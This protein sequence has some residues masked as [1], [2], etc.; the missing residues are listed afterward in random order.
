MRRWLAVGAVSMGV[1]SV[2]LMVMALP[3][4]GLV[5]FTASPSGEGQVVAV[6]ISPVAMSAYQQAALTVTGERPDCGLRWSMVAGIGKKESNHAGGRTIAGD[7][8]IEQPIIGVA[9]DGRPGLAAISDTDGGRYDGDT[10]WDRAVGP[11][12]FIPST[13]QGREADGNGDGQADPHNYYDAALSTARK[14]CADGGD[15]TNSA[16]LE[17]AVFAY[18]RST[19][20]VASVVTFIAEYDA[21]GTSGGDL[22]AGDSA[23]VALAEAQSQ[24]GKP[25][26]WAAEGPHSFDCS[27]LTLWSYAKAG[28]SI[29]R[30]AADQF[31]VGGRVE[32]DQLAPGDLVFFGPDKSDPR[33]ISH[34][35]LYMGDG[36]MLSAPRTG[37]LVRVEPIW[38]STYVGAVRLAQ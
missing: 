33:S 12:Q 22:V 15:L 25:Y 35:G 16:N 34:V 38:W 28:I 24:I 4:L 1:A 19:E 2:P 27:G 21:L 17:R 23:L 29:P 3:V 13:W 9:L 11:M 7:G 18:N 26:E 8:S 37:T 36:Q 31:N 6:D 5:G 10:V 20:Y 32:R 30:V 14:L